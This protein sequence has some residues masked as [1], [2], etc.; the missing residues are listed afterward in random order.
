MSISS[1]QKIAE[2]VLSGNIPEKY[3]CS[4]IIED[5]LNDLPEL[6][7]VQTPGNPLAR[8]L[9]VSAKSPGSAAHGSLW[10][11][12]NGS[13]VPKSL[14]YWLDGTWNQLI[15]FLQ[16]PQWRQGS[17]LGDRTTLDRTGFVLADGTNG[18]TDLR[19]LFKKIANTTPQDYSVYAVYYVGVQIVRE[20]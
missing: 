10:L 8:Y 3:K 7:S 15:N 4:S 5:L 20:E 9:Y 18:G 14:N 17:Y 6:F 11:E 12:L 19:H 2:L 13:G 1:A 16:T